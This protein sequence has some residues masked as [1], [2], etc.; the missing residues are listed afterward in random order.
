MKR[1][2]VKNIAIIEGIVLAIALVIFRVFVFRLIN[3]ERM[4]HI[5]LSTH[6]FMIGATLT[7]FCAFALTVKRAWK[8]HGKFMLLPGIFTVFGI[9]MQAMAYD[10][11]F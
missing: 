11:D 6:I 3:D 9:L 1:F 2:K 10:V 4:L 7:V 8:T 5:K